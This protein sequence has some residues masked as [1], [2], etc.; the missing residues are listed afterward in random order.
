MLF[1]FNFYG[2]VLSKKS[3]VV[4]NGCHKLYVILLQ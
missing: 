1:I 3:A 2:I 4:L